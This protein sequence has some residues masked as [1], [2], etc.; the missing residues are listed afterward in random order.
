M[1]WLEMLRRPLCQTTS[2]ELGSEQKVCPL[3]WSIQLELNQAWQASN[4]ATRRN[5]SVLCMHEP[6]QCSL[7]HQC[8]TLGWE[9][10]FDGL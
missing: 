10:L 3:G 1:Q 7:R 5:D 4:S 2:A 9:Q 8:I 6:Q